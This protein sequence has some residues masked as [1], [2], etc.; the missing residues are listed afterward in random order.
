MKRVCTLFGLAIVML[1]GMGALLG[2]LEPDLTWAQGLEAG[3]GFGCTLAGACLLG[4]A[5]IFGVKEVLR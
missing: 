5:V 1:A 3:A 4:I 2:A